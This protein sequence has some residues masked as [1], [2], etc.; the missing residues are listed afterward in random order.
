M[1]KLDVTPVNDSA[2]FFPKTGTLEFL[3]LMHREGFSAI[4]EALIGPTYDPTFVY[5][6]SGLINTGSYPAY[7]IT[8]G[9]VYYGGE[10]YLVDAASYTATGSDVAVF[11][12]VQTQYTTNADPVTLSDSTV[13]NLHNIR[14]IQTTAGAD[15]SGIANLSQAQY[16]SFLIPAQVNLTV[17]VLTP[18]TDN[19]LQIIGSYP[20]LGLYVP[21]PAPNSVLITGSVAVGN[22]SGSGSADFTV[23]FGS[24]VSTAAYTVV[25]CFISNGTPANDATLLWVVRNP[26][27]TGFVLTVREDSAVNQNVVFKFVCIKD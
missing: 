22:I 23:T 6:L 2:Q 7:S 3:Q 13:H 24:P 1:K 5:V 25:G 11:S 17:P 18:Y 16:L 14:K 8:A 15:G 19:I 9:V 27:T 21:D 26:T 4:I 20:N 10:F 12:I